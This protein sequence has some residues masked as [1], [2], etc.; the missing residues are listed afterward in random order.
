MKILF[1]FFVSVVVLSAVVLWLVYPALIGRN[2][3]GDSDGD[4]SGATT[5]SN[6]GKILDVIEDPLNQ[7]RIF[8]ATQKGLVSYQEGLVEVLDARIFESLSGARDGTI[9]ALIKGR[10]QLIAK[11]SGVDGSWRVVKNIPDFFEYLTVWPTNSKLVTSWQGR[12]PFLI[13]KSADGALSWSTSSPQGIPLPVFDFAAAA[14]DP[15]H[16][17]AAAR[18][19]VY[20]S[21]LG[22]RIWV[23][24]TNSASLKDP[25]LTI[26]VS[27]ID[28]RVILAS[29]IEGLFISLDGGRQWQKVTHPL[30]EGAIIT[31]I[32]A[33]WSDPSR[34]TIVL[35]SRLILQTRDAGK[36]WQE[37]SLLP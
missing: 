2:G 29:N 22:A 8:V 15:D 17:F 7:E 20:E 19:A 23:K 26:E 35:S 4:G 6:F 18:D 36:S 32:G 1:W 33:G 13:F 9:Y 31:S 21:A 3:N 5:I 11:R 28:P 16:Y 37:V 34:I 27:P 14:D 25:I 24:K 10:G 12:E 30:L